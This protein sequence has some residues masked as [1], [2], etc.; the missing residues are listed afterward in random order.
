M[1]SLLRGVIRDH[2]LVI[3][4]L[5]ILFPCSHLTTATTSL[6]RCLP[7]LSSKPS[8]GSWWPDTSPKAMS[9]NLFTAYSYN[10][11][12][13]ITSLFS[14]SWSHSVSGL[15][16][17]TTGEAAAYPILFSL[18]AICTERVSMAFSTWLMPTLTTSMT[19]AKHAGPV[20]HCAD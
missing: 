17:G 4:F 3:P 20:T 13:K 8:N 14:S 12:I 15:L 2:R 19:P 1:N 6:S 5:W 18:R 11:P 16:C 10:I 7:K 9:L